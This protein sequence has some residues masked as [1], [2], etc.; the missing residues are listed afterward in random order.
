MRRP[1][2]NRTRRHCRPPAK[3]SCLRRTARVA[4]RRLG[5]EER[6]IP[7][8]IPEEVEGDRRELTKRKDLQGFKGDLDWEL[9][10]ELYRR[11]IGIEEEDEQELEDTSDRMTREQTDMIGIILTGG[12]ATTE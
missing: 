8:D 10:T 6:H 5:L 1:I 3:S 2:R 12:L 7:R 9:S 11:S 4:H